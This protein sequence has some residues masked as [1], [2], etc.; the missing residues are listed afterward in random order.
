MTVE[1]GIKT[2]IIPFK[3]NGFSNN[4]KSYLLYKYKIIKIQLKYEQ[5]YN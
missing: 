4:Y 3:T 2:I 5:K 1:N